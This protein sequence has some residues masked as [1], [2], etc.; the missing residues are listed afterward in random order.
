MKNNPFAMPG[1]FYRGNL[2]SHSTNSDGL[3]SAQEV[4]QRYQGAGYDFIS[5]SEHFLEIYG[6]P[7]SDT[8]PFR[9]DSFT[10]LIAAELHQGK[11]A[12]GENWHILAV[13]LP[14]D[15][16]RPTPGETARQIAERAAA[17]GAFIGIVHPAWYGLTIEDARSIPCAHA[18]ETYNHG[19]EV[20]TERGD[21]WAFY[22]QLLNEGWRLS[23]FATDDSHSIEHDWLGGWVN[24]RA[25]S[26]D[27]EAILESLKAGHYYSSQGPE[28]HDLQVA[29]GILKVTCSAAAN[30]SLQ[31]RGRLSRYV[32]GEDLTEASFETELFEEAWVRVTV[33]DAMGKKAWSN[34]VWFN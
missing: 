23:G 30:I 3:L 4:C 5:L 22:D 20:E 7:V 31:G 21:S 29:G 18:V 10:T 15:F 12:V 2:H 14:V 28:I 27:P 6:Y 17:T 11:I 33:R 16:A 32:A 8:R 9:S 13:G 24:V 26:L 1:Q 19:S 34:P 25:K